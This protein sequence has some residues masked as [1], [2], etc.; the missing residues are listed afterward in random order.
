MNSEFG[1]SS[2]DDASV[3]QCQI[4]ALKLDDRFS[5]D[6]TEDPSASRLAM[7][8]GFVSRE[9][10]GN[11]AVESATSSPFTHTPPLLCT[12]AEP[13]SAANSDS[14]NRRIITQETKMREADTLIAKLNFPQYSSED[15]SG[16]EPDRLLAPLDAACAEVLRMVA[17][18]FLRAVRQLR[19]AWQSHFDDLIR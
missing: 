18:S 3:L 4:I 13:V 10:P 17:A 7:N 12:M 5:L 8:P 2:H 9:S 19:Y 14:G 16:R 15:R 11:T 1:G 6:Q